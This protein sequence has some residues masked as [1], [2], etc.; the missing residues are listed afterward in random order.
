MIS[1]L[2]KMG[3][4]SKGRGRGSG[5]PCLMTNSRRDKKVDKLRGGE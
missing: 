1:D 3:G 2:I 4:G 5:D